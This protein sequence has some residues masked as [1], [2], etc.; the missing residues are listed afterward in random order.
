MLLTIT[1]LL[2]ALSGY[3]IR[4]LG[5]GRRLRPREARLLPPLARILMAL[6]ISLA[7]AL[8]VWDATS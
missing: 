5:S 4:R 3:T 8:L 2:A 7:L 6:W 1:I